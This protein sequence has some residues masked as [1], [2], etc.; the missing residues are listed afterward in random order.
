[1][2]T[3]N[4]LFPNFSKAIKRNVL[5]GDIFT[6]IIESTDTIGSVLIESFT[7]GVISLIGFGISLS[8][9]PCFVEFPVEK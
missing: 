9:T 6:V 4:S 7:N 1:M 8:S 2:Y 5:P 3:Q